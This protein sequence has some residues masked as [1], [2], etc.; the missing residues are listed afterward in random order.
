MGKEIIFYRTIDG[1]CPVEEFLNS[2]PS[3]VAQKITW[4]LEIIESYDIIPAT[5]FKKLVNTN[6]WECRIQFGSNIYRILCF[7]EGNSI[8][9]LTHGFIK[10]T[11]KTP[12]SEIERAEQYF[13]DYMK[14]RKS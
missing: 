6:L 1:K 5:Y 9:I 11:Q 10:K 7:F 4:V 12:L 2:Q 3:K 8:I 13:N 14:R